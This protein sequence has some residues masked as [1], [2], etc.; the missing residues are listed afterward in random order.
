MKDNFRPYIKN[1]L[2][3]SFR[4]VNG[5]YL[6]SFD[7]CLLKSLCD[8]VDRFFGKLF[9]RIAYVGLFEVRF[10]AKERKIAVAGLPKA[11]F[12]RLK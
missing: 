3:E 6:V 1:V 9:C 5:W 7:A 4:S 11:I 8:K 12:F 2:F 10:L